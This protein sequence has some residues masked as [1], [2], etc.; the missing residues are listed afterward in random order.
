MYKY[1]QHMCTYT[2]HVHIVAAGLKWNRKPFELAE[3]QRSFVEKHLAQS[4]LENV[5]FHP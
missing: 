2:M 1:Y 3:C 5:F 4:L